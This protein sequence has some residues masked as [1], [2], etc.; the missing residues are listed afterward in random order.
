MLR[1]GAGWLAPGGVSRRRWA[2][3]SPWGG[4]WVSVPPGEPPRPSW[5]LPRHFREGPP[6]AGSF[7][8]LVLSRLP[9]GRCPF[10][11]GGR[12]VLPSG[13][14]CFWPVP[15][16]LPPEPFLRVRL[17]VLRVIRGRLCRRGGVSVCFRV[18]IDLVFRGSRKHNTLPSA[19][20]SAFRSRGVPGRRGL[21][22]GNYI[23]D[24]ASSLPNTSSSRSS[25]CVI[26]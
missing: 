12:F 1:D 25:N 18:I 22:F 23:L 10:P 9:G 4:E 26:G 14:G 21:F 13:Y 17:R 6:A 20:F 19:P 11:W 16:R 7:C 2:R 8:P 3:L 24:Y 15:S 5:R